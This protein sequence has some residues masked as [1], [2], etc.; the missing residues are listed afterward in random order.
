MADKATD[1]QKK[2]DILDADLEYIINEE[3]KLKEKLQDSSHL[4]RFT[5]DLMLFVSLIKDYYK[6]NY[7][8]IPYKTISA[9]V[10][11]LL[12]TLNPIDIIPDF[13]P[14]IGH[15]DDALVLAFC[16]KLIEKD[17]QKYQTWKKAQSTAKSTTDLK[18][19]A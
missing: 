1:K 15:I 11:G 19:N 5:K 2:D 18:K 7:R 4:E 8:D 9:G 10:V 12:Y 14:F 16:L 6:G 13:I 3:E 17:L